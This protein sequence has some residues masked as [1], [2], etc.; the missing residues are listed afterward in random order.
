MATVGPTEAAGPVLA[1]APVAG[2]VADLGPL[3]VDDGSAFALDVAAGGF[4]IGGVC[5]GGGACAGCVGCGGGFTGG[6]LGDAALAGVMDTTCTNGTA[7]AAV[8]PAAAPRFNRSRR[9]GPAPVLR[10]LCI[11]IPRIIRP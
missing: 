9:L 8:T 11:C 2:S 5:T 4:S 6:E 7:Q 3:L 1:S 10:S